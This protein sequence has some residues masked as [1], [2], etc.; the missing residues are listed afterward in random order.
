MDS[1]TDVSI[2]AFRLFTQTRRLQESTSKA[3]TTNLRGLLSWHGQPALAHVEL[4]AQTMAWLNNGVSEGKSPATVKQWRSSVREYARW[5][6]VGGPGF[7]YQWRAPKEAPPDP[8]PLPEGMA[9]IHRLIAVCRNPDELA[10]V[11]LCGFMGLRVG[12]ATET[13]LASCV[14]LHAIGGP[15]L[16]VVGKGAKPRDLPIPE[17]ALGAVLAVAGRSGF[18]DVP[19]VRINKDV[20][21]K[22]FTHLGIEANLSRRISS[23]DARATFATDMYERTL[24]VVAVQEHMGHAS[25]TTTMRYIGTSMARK[26][27]AMLPGVKAAA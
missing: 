1:L 12:E 14:E 7:L 8:H 25:I 23:H 17:V 13:T 2:E 24:D 21:R 5:A 19:L 15:V 11:S 10:L 26:R 9:G 3:Y 16:H 22:R 18:A 20:A 6:G 4:E 27:A